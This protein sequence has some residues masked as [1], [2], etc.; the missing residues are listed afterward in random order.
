MVYCHLER[1]DGAGYPNGLRCVE[2]PIMAQIV[3]FVDVYDALTSSRPYRQA[4]SKKE[5]LEILSEESGK[6]FNPELIS[7]FLSKLIDTATE[8]KKAI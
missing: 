3:S 6:S 8:Y 7:F 2:I 1:W 5:V 4:F